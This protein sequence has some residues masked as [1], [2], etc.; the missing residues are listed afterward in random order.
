MKPF[1][2]LASTCKPIIPMNE[3]FTLLN[4]NI[5]MKTHHMCLEKARM[6]S[7]LCIFRNELSIGHKIHE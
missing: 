1:D 2:Y 4:A 7:R 6:K 3:L 5:I